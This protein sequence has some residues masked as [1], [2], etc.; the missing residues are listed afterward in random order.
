MQ[1]V[2]SFSAWEKSRDSTPNSPNLEDMQSTFVKQDISYRFFI[3]WQLPDDSLTT[4]WRLPDDCLT[5]AWRLPD[6]CLMTA[7]NCLTTTWWLH[8]P[9]MTTK[10]FK[11]WFCSK[12]ETTDDE[13][14]GLMC[15]LKVEWCLFELFHFFQT[16]QQID[17]QQI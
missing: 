10:L 8:S 1:A 7:W 3:I 16:S 11:R 15:N 17:I 4:A 5:T 2:L 12:L 14:N 13:N 9:K 6:D